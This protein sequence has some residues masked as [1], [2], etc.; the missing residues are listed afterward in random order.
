[1]DVLGQGELPAG[2]A[3]AQKRD[4]LGGLDR[5]IA[6]AKERAKIDA[7]AD[8]EIVPFPA[9]KSFFEVVSRTVPGDAQLYAL[10]PP[11]PGLRFY[12]PPA[13]AAWPAAGADGGHLLLWEDELQRL[14]DP[15]GRPLAVLAMSDARQSGR[16]HLALV[17][18]PRGPLVP[19]PTVVAPIA[20]RT[21]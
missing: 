17:S 20:P 14:R 21:R 1:V 15:R 2:E 16:G 3:G 13:L 9:P 6:T 5:A 8:V 18:A 7:G 19:A 10:F 11:D 4:Q 12:A